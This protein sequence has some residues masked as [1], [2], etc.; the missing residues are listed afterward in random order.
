[1][2]KFSGGGL[3]DQSFREDALHLRDKLAMCRLAV[4]S[5]RKRLIDRFADHGRFLLDR[6]HTARAASKD[7]IPG[8]H[9]G[10]QIHK[11]TNETSKAR[12]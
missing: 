2:L 11:D 10:D 6:I 9:T 8:T 1:M 3:F 7:Q 12:L 4:E 5:F